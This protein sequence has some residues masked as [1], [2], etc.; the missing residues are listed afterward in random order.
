[1]KK[2]DHHILSSSPWPL[3][4]SIFSFI[5]AFGVVFFIHKKSL[6]YVFLPIGAVST[7]LVLYF[8]WKD[9]IRE[10]IRDQCFTEVV[11]TGLRL[12][13]TVMILSETM[14]FFA[15]F[16][17]F[18]KAW[19]FPAYQL[20]DFSK[21]VA[22]TWPP[23]GIRTVSPWTIPFLNTV[24]LLLSGCTITWSHHFLIENNMKEARRMLFFTI[25]LGII[26]SAFQ[27][28][29]YMH[30]GFAFSEQ[31][32]KAIYSSNFY[33]ATGFHGMHVIMGIISLIV[34]LIRM[35]KGQL[36][37]SCHIG[38][39]CAAWYWHFVDVI[40]LFLFLFMYVLSS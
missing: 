8:W 38:F 27:A 22:S 34:C 26:F 4:L 11:K 14:F 13:L 3:F 23:A 16:W 40:W 10:A 39:E 29:E 32:P 19:L 24:T 18:F 30:A 1:M 37:P 9:V 31:G 33:M 20:V 21:K 35:Y 6:G 36:S 2:H 17:S 12:G 25:C 5:T 7:G 15:F 28:L